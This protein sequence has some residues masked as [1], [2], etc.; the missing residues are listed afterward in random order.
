MRS[1]KRIV[2]LLEVRAGVETVVVIC[3]KRTTAVFLV[4]VCWLASRKIVACFGEARASWCCRGRLTG[5]WLKNTDLIVAQEGGGKGGRGYGARTIQ[6]W[7]GVLAL[8]DRGAHAG[9]CAWCVCFSWP[10]FVVCP[11]CF[12]V[13]N[14]SEGALKFPRVPTPH[15]LLS[16]LPDGPI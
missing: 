14:A 16:L 6:R 4:R 15:L 13:S 9:P 3:N 5:S 12:F 2:A 1:F 10:L 11:I 8:P 7:R